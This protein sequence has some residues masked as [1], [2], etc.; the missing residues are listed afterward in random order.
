MRAY[1]VD[2]QKSLGGEYWTNRYLIIDASLED[3]VTTG[4]AIA[5]AERQ[6]HY[7]NVIF[8]KLRVSTVAIHDNVYQI[9]ALGTT[10]MLTALT[11]YL[12]LWNVVRVDWNVNGGGRP[13]RKYLRLPVGEGN[14]NKGVLAPDVITFIENNYIAPI[15]DLGAMVDPQS[16]SIIG[17]VVMPLIGMRQLRRGSKKKKPVI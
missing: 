4:T 14:Q 16:A 5:E 2:I 9:V 15:I 10:G 3:A 8:D 7:A 6:V 17:G 1:S 13:S 11:D 12:P